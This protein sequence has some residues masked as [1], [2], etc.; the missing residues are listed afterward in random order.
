MKKNLRFIDLYAGIGGIR[1]GFENENCQCVFSSEIDKYAQQTYYN[2][3]KET[4]SGDITK[5]TID[6]IPKF[7]ILLAGFPCQ[8]FSKAGLQNGFADIRG[9][10]FFDIIEIVKY[11][12]PE[13]IFLENVKNLVSHDNGKTFE[14]IINSLKQLNYITYYKTLNAKDFGLPQNRNRIY[15]VAFKNKINFN[16]PIGNKIKT[17]VFDILED[18]VSEK[19]TISDKL[20]S[21]HQERKK[22]NKQNGKGFGY[23]L[24]D[25]NT[26]Y[27]STLSARYYKDGSEILIKQNN[28]NPRKITPREAARLQGFP[29]S[30]IISVSDVQAYK[31]FGNSVAIP[32][33][34]EIANKIF[35]S[36]NN[37][38]IN[39]E[40]Y[41]QWF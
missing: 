37:I 31:Q 33:I 2:N 3:F 27:T 38:N 35:N 34:K 9:T 6:R 23:S 8:S 24:C 39:V 15:I 4:P 7:D 29:D 18:T 12:R 32:V 1:L 17:K 40:D 5:I 21:G 10:A 16:F 41:I 22:R 20:W 28:Q 25:E 13:V 36:L 19:Y 14:I 26:E 11:H 30:F